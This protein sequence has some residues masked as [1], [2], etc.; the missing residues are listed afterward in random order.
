MHAGDFLR[1]QRVGEKTETVA[2]VFFRNQTAVEPELAHFDD[3]VFAKDMFPVIF[4]CG[5]SDFFLGEVA[6][7]F[8]YFG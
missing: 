6:R 2:A 3:E 5:G 1:D 4:R 7:Q 8:L